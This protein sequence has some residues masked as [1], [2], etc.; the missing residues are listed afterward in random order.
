VAVWS[1]IGANEVWA[2]ASLVALI[3]DWWTPTTAGAAWTA[4]QAA[5]VAGFAALQ[6]RGLHQRED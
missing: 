3:A 2:T 6:T 1:V 4:V 5:T